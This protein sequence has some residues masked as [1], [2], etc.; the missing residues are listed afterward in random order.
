MQTTL[1]L[2]Y[3]PNPPPLSICVSTIVVQTTIFSYL[4]QHS[5]LL[6]SLMTL[7]FAPPPHSAERSHSCWSIHQIV[8]LLLKCYNDIPLLLEQNPSSLPWFI[9]PFVN[10][11]PPSD[12]FFSALFFIHHAQNTLAFFLLVEFSKLV[13]I[14]ETVHLLFLLPGT[15]PS[16]LYVIAS[17]LPLSFQLQCFCLSIPFPTTSPKVAPPLLS[18]I[19]PYLTDFTVSAFC[20]CV[21]GRFVLS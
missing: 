1:S 2:K 3:T 4:D 17:F 13:S 8:T 21:W 10:W 5:S 12:L 15:P 19:L 14:S 20:V 6:T 9:S 11:S 7:T 16:D 18:V